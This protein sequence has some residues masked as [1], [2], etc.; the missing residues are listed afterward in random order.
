MARPIV[1]SNGELHVG[2]N[3][4]GMVHDFYYPFVG[5]ENHCAGDALRH[6]VGVWV[7]N[8]FSW[9]YDASAWT[10]KFQYPHD[11][12]V[13]HTIAT[14]NH[15]GIIVEF[16]DFVDAN[17]SA[18]IRNIHIINLRPQKREV[19]CAGFLFRTIVV[20]LYV[21]VHEHMRAIPTTSLRFHLV[22]ARPNRILLA[23]FLA[24]SILELLS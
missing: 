4:F 1:L 20:F 22:L 13:G 2:L 12:L 23:K 9:L 21:R 10:F 15:L 16:D 19:L 8:E 14:N 3:N 17:M 18:F 7:D 6:K 5:S 24:L 11:A